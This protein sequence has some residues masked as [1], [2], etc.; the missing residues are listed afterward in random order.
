MSRVQLWR[1][2]LG[3]SL[4]RRWLEVTAFV[5][6]WIAVGKI[7]H[8]SA[9]IYLL[10]G[11]P[12][13]ASFQLLVRKK[14]IRELWV[15]DGPTFSLRT[16]SLK[17]ASLLAIIPLYHLLVGVSKGQGLGY[18]LYMLAVLAGAGAAAYALSQFRRETW[19]YLMLCLATAGLLG[20]LLMVDAAWHA[21]SAIHPVGEPLQPNALY[22]IDSLLV[23]VP[24]LFMME[25]VA[26]RGAIDTHVYYLPERH[27]RASVV[28]GVASAILVS[29]LWGLWHYPI[30]PG[31]SVMQLLVVQG[32]VGPFLSLFWRRSA[33]LMVPGFAHAVIDSVRNAFGF[34]P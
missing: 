23:Y 31:A 29:F 11:I 13:T 12:L 14:P 27:S 7:L 4:L 26:F 2:S 34:I 6:F 18:V 5:G 25:E 3:L 1:G 9:D 24:A 30:V 32:L 33:N 19:R 28:Y 21:A 16:I 17:L 8:M 10:F 22:G 15:R 20:V